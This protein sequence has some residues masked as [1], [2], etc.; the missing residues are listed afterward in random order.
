MHGMSEIT[1]EETPPSCGCTM[2]GGY[3]GLTLR[4]SE[5]GRGMRIRNLKPMITIL[6]THDDHVTGEFVYVGERA[7]LAAI[8]AAWFDNYI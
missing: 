2:L 4:V 6:I 8:R 7:E 1:W 3:G 5:N